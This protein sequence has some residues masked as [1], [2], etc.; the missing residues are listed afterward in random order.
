MPCHE[1]KGLL[2]DYIVDNVD[3]SVRQT[4]AS[5]IAGCPECARELQA[6]QRTA[7]LVNTIPLTEP[8]AGLWNK[9]APHLA[10]YKQKK[11]GSSF[12]WWNRFEWLKLKPIPVFASAIIICLIIGGLWWQHGSIITP[13]PMQTK[14]QPK[15]NE[16]SIELYAAQHNAATL[17]DPAT[18]KNSA[19]LLL[20]SAEEIN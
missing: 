13:K 12:V 16:D 14:I 3:S 2:S 10:E 17:E 15:A 6:L 7:F 9:I 1:V 4:I 8:P 18:D 5:H 20:V 11:I 19:A